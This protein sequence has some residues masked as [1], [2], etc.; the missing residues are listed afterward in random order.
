MSAKSMK[1]HLPRTEIMLQRLLHESEVRRIELEMKNSDLRDARDKA[2]TTL[3]EYPDL[4]DFAPVGYFTLDRTG[5][6]R[7]VNLTGACLLGIRRTKL[8]GRRF[9]L[10]VSHEVRPV[11]IAF[12]EKIFESGDIGS[13]E[14]TLKKDGMRPLKVQIQAVAGK[15]GKDCRIAV[16]DITEHGHDGDRLTENRRELNKINLSL[17]RAQDELRTKDQLLITQGRLAV[18][19]EM[20]DNIAHQWRQP[21]CALGLIVQQVQL[22]YGS[23]GFSREFLD[24]NTG[25]AMHL[26]RHMSRTIDDFRDF[27]RSDKEMTRFH[28][29]QVISQTLSLIEDSFNSR[30]ISIDFHTESD[31]MITGYPNEYAQALLNILVNAHDALVERNVDNPRIFLRTFAE[32]G[33]TVLTITDN[34]GGIAEEI[35]GRLFDPYFTTKGPDKGTGI[36][37]FMSKTIIEKNMGGRLTA[38]NNRQGAEFRIEA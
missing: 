2:E 35:I 21:L 11:F 20:I 32:K 26:I 8:L 5:I 33:K 16:I 14:V 7:G 4:Y 3:G 34:A 36:G 1:V 29:N 28:V 15:S 38:R 12:I 25:K 24:E 22:L 30:Q 9:G 19:G 18:M 13:C 10:F 6:I 31:P 37:L 17:V 27:F 23:A